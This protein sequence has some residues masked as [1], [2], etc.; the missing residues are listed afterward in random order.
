MDPGQWLAAARAFNT[1]SAAIDQVLVERHDV[2]L[3]WFEVLSRL[4]A[5]GGTARV[6]LLSEGISIS[7]PRVSRVLQLMVERGLVTKSVPKDDGRG[8]VVALTP[9]GWT[10][11]QEAT[12]T[13]SDQLKD[14]P[15]PR[16]SST[17]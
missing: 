1:A 6:T 8:T 11:L 15:P 17:A 3:T 12:A 14:F 10:V 7:Q 2:C 5:L 13:F 4:D 16:S 9:A